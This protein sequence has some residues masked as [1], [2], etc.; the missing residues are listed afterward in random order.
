MHTDLAPTK[1]AH[2]LCQISLNLSQPCYKVTKYT[3][4]DI[5]LH[6]YYR[7]MSQSVENTVLKKFR[8]EA[9]SKAFVIVDDGS[10]L[11]ASPSGWVNV[12]AKTWR[13][14]PDTYKD[15]EAFIERLEREKSFMPCVSEESSPVVTKPK[16]KRA[17][18]EEEVVPSKPLTPA[19]SSGHSERSIATELVQVTSLDSLTFSIDELKNKMCEFQKMVDERLTSLENEVRRNRDPQVAEQV[20][21]VPMDPEVEEFMENYFPIKTTS[22]M[23]VLEKDLKSNLGLCEILKKFF[24]CIM[25]HEGPQ[26]RMKGILS[27]MCD[28]IIQT[29]Y[30]W[31]GKHD[32]ASLQDA[33]P[34]KFLTNVIKKMPA[35]RAMKEAD[36]KKYRESIKQWGTTWINTSR[37]SLRREE[38]KQN[39]QSSDTSLQ[40]TTR[41]PSS[42]SES[43]LESEVETETNRDKSVT[44]TESLP[45]R[46]TPEFEPIQQTEVQQTEV[47]QMEVQQTEQM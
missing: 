29:T 1:N 3:I 18:R 21:I 32:K 12:K 15:A 4:F 8:G 42:S 43:N 26:K 39:S 17:R 45:G 28:R 16:K 37:D 44:L 20:V 6:L 46:L 34:I 19:Q 2:D 27:A 36:K 5:L 35:M 13:R 33:Y 7:D 25:P 22:D 38:E 14:S 41:K 40:Q 23:E 10:G 30:T 11:I 31:Q 9:L 47:Q 24:S